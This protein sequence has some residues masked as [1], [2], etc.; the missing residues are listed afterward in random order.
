MRPLPTG[1]PSSLRA[2]GFSYTRS[3]VE[4]SARVSAEPAGAASCAAATTAAVLAPMKTRR[5][6][7]RAFRGMQQFLFHGQDE[8]SRRF[9]F[10]Q[11]KAI[12]QQP[13]VLRPMR[14]NRD[15]HFLDRAA[16]DLHLAI[17]R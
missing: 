1:M 9:D 7:L 13:A 6:T 10:L 11:R 16:Y 12:P 4:T 14:R 15:L 17:G 8:A 3:A 5:D 2:T